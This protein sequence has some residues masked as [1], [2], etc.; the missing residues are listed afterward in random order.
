MKEVSRKCVTC[1]EKLTLPGSQKMADLLRS[2]L[3]SH[4]PP[5]FYI[6]LDCFGPYLVK[7]GIA[8]IKRYGCVF[9]CFTTRAV[10]LEKINTLDTDS[11]I[12]ALRHFIS[13]RV[14][15]VLYIVLMAHIL[16]GHIEC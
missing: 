14:V 9:T 2:R 11:L 4:H 3:T 15:R 16:R 6:A 13:R 8:Q 1:R 5:F 10:H 7:Y 12:N